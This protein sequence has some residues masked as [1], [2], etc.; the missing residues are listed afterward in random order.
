MIQYHLERMFPLD[1]FSPNVQTS[2]QLKIRRKKY[3]RETTHWMLKAQPKPPQGIPLT[4]TLTRYSSGTLDSDNLAGAFK[5]C[6][7]GVA[8]YLGIDDGD[9]SLTWA[10]AQSKIARSA[11]RHIKVTIQG[12]QP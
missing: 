5:A 12:T 11:M 2:L 7:D 4:I 8:D 6:R 1:T 9:P 3:Q 10:Y